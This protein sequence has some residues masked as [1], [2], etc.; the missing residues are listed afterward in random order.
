MHSRTT[1]LVSKIID[2]QSDIIRTIRALCVGPGGNSVEQTYD[3]ASRVVHSFISTIT[4]AHEAEISFTSPLYSECLLT[5][6]AIGRQIGSQFRPFDNAIRRCLSSCK[7]VPQDCAV[8]AI[9]IKFS[10]EL[11]RGSYNDFPCCDGS[12]LRNHDLVD[13]NLSE[14]GRVSGIYRRHSDTESTGNDVLA[15]ALQY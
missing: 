11:M 4:L 10:V 12:D 8:V 3:I 15:S 2:C 6:T 9:Y 1:S 7:V 5:I 14:L 13:N